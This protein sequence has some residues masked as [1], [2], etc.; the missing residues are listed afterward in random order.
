MGFV[1]DV[2]EENIQEGSQELDQTGELA[3]IFI[4]R[5]CECSESGEE[6]EIEE[7]EDDQ[8]EESST[9]QSGL[10]DF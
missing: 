4:R 7:Y 9:E 3:H 6:A 10:S 8:E 2:G 1:Q 5:F